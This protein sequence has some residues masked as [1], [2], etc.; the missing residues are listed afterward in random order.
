MVRKTKMPRS[1]EE[2]RGITTLAIPMIDGNRAPG[3]YI[4]KFLL[5]E[6]LLDHFPRYLNSP[7]D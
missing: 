2:N 6:I 1:E 5:L 7:E 4:N 3:L